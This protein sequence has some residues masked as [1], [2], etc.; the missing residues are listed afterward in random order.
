MEQTKKCRT[1][2]TY[3][4]A[5]AFRNLT[6]A[7][8]STGE[9]KIDSG[10]VTLDSFQATS[11]SWTGGSAYVIGDFDYSDFRTVKFVGQVSDGTDVDAFEV[12][13]TYKGASAP[14]D[15]AAIFMTTYAYMASSGSPLGSVTAVKEGTGGTVDLKFTPGSN[16]TYKYAVT[17]T[18]IAAQ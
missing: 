5:S 13:V 16:G 4:D 11:Q 15:D 17:A 18:K 9:L 12:L 3:K 1:C 10:N 6:A 7:S 14:A 2:Q 8:M